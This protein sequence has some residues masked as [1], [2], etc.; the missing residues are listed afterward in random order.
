MADSRRQTANASL[1]GM[2]VQHLGEEGC[3]WAQGPR[4]T[5]CLPSSFSKFSLLPRRTTSPHGAHWRPSEAQLTSQNG[6][7]LSV[8]PS[9]HV[10]MAPRHQGL[11]CLTPARRQGFTDGWDSPWGRCFHLRQCPTNTARGSVSGG[12]CG[13][14]IVLWEEK[15][16]GTPLSAWKGRPEKGRAG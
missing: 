10:F 11:P 12:E 7:H 4:S 15:G 13:Q 1:R 6:H 2:T 14:E 16:Q 5:A 3:L 8:C 9:I